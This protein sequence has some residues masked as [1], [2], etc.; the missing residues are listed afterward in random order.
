[1]L[2][3]A[4][5]ADGFIPDPSQSTRLT[6]PPPETACT[7]TRPPLCHHDLHAPCGYNISA[8]NGT[9]YSPGFPEEYPVLQDCLWL[10]TAPPGH[11]IYINFTL[12]QTE[13][14]NDYIA[15]W[16]G[17][18]QSAAQLGVFSGNTALETARSSTR[19]VLLG[20]HS[21]FSNG[22]FFVLNFHAFQLKKCPPPPAVPQAELLREDEDFE[23]GD[24]VRYV[25]H[26]GYALSGSDTLTCKLG[27]QLQ[28]QGSLPACEGPHGVFGGH[29]QPGYPGNYFNSQTCSWTIRVEP[30]YNIT[31]FVDSFQSEKQFDALEVFDGTFL[32]AVCI[33]VN[34]AWGASNTLIRVFVSQERG[35]IIALNCM[36]P[37]GSEL[38]LHWA[39][40]ES[41]AANQEPSVNAAAVNQSEN[42]QCPDSVLPIFPSFFTWDLGG[43][44]HTSSLLAKN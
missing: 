44:P 10:L 29:P 39:I 22:G 23:I 12:L 17:P 31:L 11:G 43:G 32:T 40:S 27:A 3:A 30:R 13:A 42:A 5:A 2:C 9:I 18:D 25:C 26:P 21:D 6:V 15:V 38:L 20:F 16:D 7:V 33:P 4:P 14:I 36:S 28:F 37:D 8:P 24:S 35:D 41:G 19:H 34:S 1:M